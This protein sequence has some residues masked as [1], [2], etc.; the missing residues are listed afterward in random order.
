LQGAVSSAVTLLCALLG[1][2]ALSAAPFWLVAVLA[3]FIIAKVGTTLALPLKAIRAIEGLRPAS[4]S[5]HPRGESTPPTT[6]AHV[7]R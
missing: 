5:P 2:A 6:A 1:L 3:L 4:M 7:E